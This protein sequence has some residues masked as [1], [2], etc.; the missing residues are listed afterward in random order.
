MFFS[1]IIQVC[2]YKTDSVFLFDI[3]FETKIKVLRKNGKRAVWRPGM[4][5]ADRR[6]RRVLDGL[7]GLPGQGEADGGR[8]KLAARRALSRANRAPHSRQCIITLLYKA[9]CKF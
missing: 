7:D 3:K 9:Q 8:R 1:L 5:R 2:T 4:A 6:V